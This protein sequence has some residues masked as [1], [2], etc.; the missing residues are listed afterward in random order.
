MA[1]TLNERL[2]GLFGEEAPIAP[3]NKA[4]FEAL[5]L[6]IR[7]RIKR[8]LPDVAQS[9]LA[10]PSLL[11]AAVAV[12]RDRNELTI[13]DEPALRKAGLTLEADELIARA[14]K[15]EIRKLEEDLAA[16]RE[17]NRIPEEHRQQ[18]KA[19]QE[20]VRQASRNGWTGRV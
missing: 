15:V 17:S 8:D 2:Y 11:P 4:E 5:P 20:R 10:D 9:F 14:R 3:R 19:E 18:A 13:A 1:Q 12:R 7:E 16:F 6:T